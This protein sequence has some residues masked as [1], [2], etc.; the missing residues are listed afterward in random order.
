MKREKSKVGWE[1]DEYKRRFFPSNESI[2]GGHI[3]SYKE[4]VIDISI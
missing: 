1:R 3:L 2:H 4:Y